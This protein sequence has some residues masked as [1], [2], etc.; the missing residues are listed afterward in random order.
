[1]PLAAITVLSHFGTDRQPVYCIS[2]KEIEAFVA[3]ICNSPFE[4]LISH[5]R[6]R[7]NIQNIAFTLGHC[8][9]IIPLNQ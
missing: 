7:K 9:T 2:I 8:I 5:R 6:G 4:C 1:M 3:S